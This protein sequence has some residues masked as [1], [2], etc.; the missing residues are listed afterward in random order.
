MGKKRQNGDKFKQASAVPYRC[1]G[2][3]IEFCLITSRSKRRWCFP[4][5]II[6][7]GETPLEAALKEAEEE[8]GLVGEICGPPLGNYEYSKWDRSLS[9]VVMLMKVH[10]AADEWEE[11]Q[12]RD[13]RWAGLEDA[14]NLLGRRRLQ[15]FLLQA[16]ERLEVGVSKT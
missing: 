10:A 11:S 1:R 13:R 3:E 9:V 7:P 4:K 16:A 14:M 2:G 15:E 12:L 8:A 6:D 5:G